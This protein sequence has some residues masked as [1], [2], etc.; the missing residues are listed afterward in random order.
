MALTVAKKVPHP[1]KIKISAQMK[2]FE[3]EGLFLCIVVVS[4]SCYKQLW[5]YDTLATL[6]GHP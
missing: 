4:C 5:S 2:S 1:H 3:K 6:C